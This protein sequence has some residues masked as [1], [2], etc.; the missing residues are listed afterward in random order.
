MT[1]KNIFEIIFACFFPIFSAEDG[2]VEWFD[3]LEM[4]R[5]LKPLVQRVSERG[6]Q[7]V[8]EGGRE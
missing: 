1:L 2:V 8:M 4:Q 3:R 5:Y 6:R 7:G